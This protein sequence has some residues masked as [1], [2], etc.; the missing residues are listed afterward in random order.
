MAQS[1]EMGQT[2]KTPPPGSIVRTTISV[3]PSYLPLHDV[4]KV[5]FV[6]WESRMPALIFTW[7]GK[8]PE[9]VVFSL[10]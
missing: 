1:P 4:A 10:H 7:V 5:M 2:M 9:F 6:H 8:Q 3:R